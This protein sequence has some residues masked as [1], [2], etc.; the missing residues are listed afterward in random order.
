[1]GI[2]DS[3][4]SQTMRTQKT[5]P[6]RKDE[7]DSKLTTPVCS[8]VEETKRDGRVSSCVFS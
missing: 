5:L 6:S 1:M 3:V 7:P 2:V 8:S 4:D